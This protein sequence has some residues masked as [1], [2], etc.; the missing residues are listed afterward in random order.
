MHLGR[1]IAAIREI[2]GWKQETLASKLNISQQQCSKIEQSETLTDSMLAR[3]AEALEMDAEQI[4]AYSPEKFINHIGGQ[5]NVVINYVVNYT[6][7]GLDKEDT[8]RLIESLQRLT[9]RK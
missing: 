2:K 1:N 5:N 3:I 6:I 4:K 7:N 9:Q 8:A